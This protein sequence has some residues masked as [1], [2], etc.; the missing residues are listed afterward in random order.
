MAKR[1]RAAIDVHLVVRDF[2]MLHVAQHDRGE[3]LVQLEQVDI[4]EGHLGPLEQLLGH[5]DGTGEHKRRVGADIGEGTDFRTRLKAERLA[6]LLRAHQHG[7][8]TVH[9][10][11]RISRMV[12]ML[13]RFHI[14]MR[15]DGDGIE[16]AHLTHHHEGRIERSQRL[17]VGAGPHVLVLVQ[18]GKAV[19]VLDRRDGFG[20]AAVLPA[21]LRALL[22][23]HRIGVDIVAREAPFRGD[24][25]GGY[26]LRHEVGGNSDR[27]VHRPCAAGSPHA[28]AAHRFH[29]ARYHYIV[30]TGS[31]LG[32][33]HVDGVEAR[34][35]E[36]V[37]LHARDLRVVARLEHGGAR[38]VGTGFTNRIDATKDH[39]V[40]LRGVHLVALL[41]RLQRVSR[42]ADRR[43]FVQAAILLALAAGRANVIV[44][45]CFGHDKPPVGADQAAAGVAGSSFSGAAQFSSDLMRVSQASMPG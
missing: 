18:N 12:D 4:V 29:T 28:D 17:H 23:F 34:G 32:G 40:H 5:V 6:P 30:G 31:N 19:N 37:D 24:Q 25:I 3:G 39:I 36:P 45:E 26:A 44:N 14:R 21:C 7:G 16:T 2:E 27:W 43:H 35:A 10:T 38:N 11:G 33:R 15:L 22:A 13:D 9:D 42:K 20:E 8:G 41:E 1:D